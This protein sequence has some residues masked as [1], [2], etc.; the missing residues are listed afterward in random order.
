M[1]LSNRKVQAVLV[2]ED[3]P[4][5]VII[6]EHLYRTED[7]RI[8]NESDKSARWLYAARGTRIPRDE[9]ERFGIVPPRNAPEENKARK[10]ESKK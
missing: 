2:D 6:R 5:W 8:V 3:G 7:N 4:D 1:A 9:A 10:P